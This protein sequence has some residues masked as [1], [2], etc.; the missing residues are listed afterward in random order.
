MYHYNDIILLLG[1]GHEKYQEIKGV[2]YPFD[3]KKIID[4]YIKYDY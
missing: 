2:R 1:K 3:E 4:D